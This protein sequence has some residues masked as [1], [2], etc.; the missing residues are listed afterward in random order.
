MTSGAA[1]HRKKPVAIA[2]QIRSRSD[3]GSFHQTIFDLFGP[4]DDGAFTPTHRALL[5]LPFDAFV[6]TN[7]DPGLDLACAAVDPDRRAVPF[8]WRDDRIS[9]WGKRSSKELWILHA[10][11]R[12]D[13]SKT[14][15][16][17]I[18]D[19]REVSSS[20]LF[21]RAL[22]RSHAGCLDAEN[23]PALRGGRDPDQSLG[24]SVPGAPPGTTLPQFCGPAQGKAP[25]G[26]S[27]RGRV[28]GEGVGG[29][30]GAVPARR[31]PQPNYGRLPNRLPW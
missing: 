7:Y 23:P 5:S 14:K 29:L 30:E 11:G 6:T 31:K 21:Y 2:K 13:Q 22:E 28:A 1:R 26:Y 19:Y 16:L 12:Y 18:D 10:H 17:D 8:T 25:A 24:G 20:C 9:L 3:L 15:V 27:G 4:R